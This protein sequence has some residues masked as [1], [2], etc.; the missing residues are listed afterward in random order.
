MSHG[1]SSWSAADRPGWRRARLA[2]LRGHRVTLV[3][4]SGHLGGRF[5]LAAATDQPNA[6][7]LRWLVTQVGK[8]D[9]DVR[10]GC[11]VDADDLATYAPDEVVIATGAAWERPAVPGAELPHVLTVDGLDRLLDLGDARSVGTRVVV[12]GGNRAGLSIA[13]A[14][15]SRG[16]E[17]TVAES[18]P[19]FATAY[20][21]PGRWRLVHEARTLGIELEPSSTVEAI[22][23][24]LVEL[25]SPSGHRSTAADL[26]IITDGARPHAPLVDEIRARGVSV[27]AVGDCRDVALVEGAMLDAAKVAVAL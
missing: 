25:R 23:P 14:M 9:V 13:K 12:I 7:L 27:Q 1:T 8:L 21:L 5:R 3:E 11:H 22:T 19:V 24:D 26:V 10:L 4:A 6:E 2:A 17:V 15:R 20:G 16:C 18:T